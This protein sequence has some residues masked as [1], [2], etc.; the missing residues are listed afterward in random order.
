MTTPINLSQLLLPGFRKIYGDSYAEIPTQYDKVFELDSS[1]MAKEEDQ[2]LSTLGLAVEKP[3]MKSI[4]FDTVYQGYTKTYTPTTYALGFMIAK[5][6]WD[7]SLYRNVK[8]LPKALGRSVRHTVEILG[9]SVLNNAF[10]ASYLGADSKELCA[11]D[12]PLLGGGTFRN[13]LTT[14]ADLDIV[15][16]EQCLIDMRSFVD[17]RGLKVVAKPK[18]LVIPP[19]LE[20][21]AK[22]LLKSDKLPDTANNN[23]NPANGMV[24]YIVLDWLTD[25]D[26]FFILTD[27]PNGMNF[28]WRDKPRFGTEDEWNSEVSKFK[29]VFRCSYGWTDPRCIFGSPGA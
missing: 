20:F 4:T 11:T 8:Q 9:A 19:Q 23:I 21:T 24:P 10:S 28:I 7:D 27:I 6:T 13:E 14:S 17:D 22:M 15:S 5:E 25:P 16:F 26:A 12:H 1:S 3:A 2:G 18:L 29:A